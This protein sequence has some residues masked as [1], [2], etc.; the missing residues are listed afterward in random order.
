MPLH[1]R[2]PLYLSA[3]IFL[4]VNPVLAQ[5]LPM[6]PSP[7]VTLDKNLADTNIKGINYLPDFTDP[8]AG[9]VMGLLQSP[10]NL[11]ELYA[12]TVNGGV[13][14]SSNGGNSWTAMGDHLA[15]LSIGAITFD[16]TNPTKLWIGFGKLSSLGATGG[17]LAG[18]RVL[19]TT[20]NTW[21]MPAMAGLVK[22]DVSGLVVNGNTIVLGAKTETGAS[23]IWRSVDAGASFQNIT[24]GLSAGAITSLVKG[25]G[26]TLYAAILNDSSV[27]ATGVY[28][29]DDSGANW[30]QLSTLN[31]LQNRG[32]GQQMT[33]MIR[34]SVGKDGVLVASLANPTITQSPWHTTKT[35]YPNTPVSV[36]MS[37]DKGANWTSLGI[38]GTNEVVNGVPFFQNVYQSGQLMHGRVLA[39]PNDASIFYIS[40]DA[41][42]PGALISKNIKTSIGADGWSGRLFR[43]NYNAT[44]GETLWTAITDNYSTGTVTGVTGS[45]PHADSRFMMIDGMGNLLQ[46]DDGGI[47]KRTLPTRNDGAWQSLNGNL[48]VGEVHTARWNSTTHTAA[49]TNQDNGANIQYQKYQPLHVVVGGG[50]GGVVAINPNVGVEEGRVKSAIYS[51][52]QEFGNFNRLTVSDPDDILTR[53]FLY[54]YIVKADETKSYLVKNPD[55]I[56]SQPPNAKPPRRPKTPITYG[57]ALASNANADTIAMQ[58]IPAMSLNTVDNRR[59]ALGGYEVFVGVDPLTDPEDNLLRIQVRQVTDMKGEYPA[60]STYGF[61]ALQYGAVNNTSALV[62]GTGI[63]YN[64]EAAG[65]LVFSPNVE[66]TLATTIHTSSTGYQAAL[67]DKQL[68]TNRIYATNSIDIIR[69][70]PI[71]GGNSYAF[72]NLN[73]NLSENNFYARRAL[74]HIYKYGVS[75]LVAGGVHSTE[76][77]NFLYTLRDPANVV[78]PVWDTRLGSIPNAAIWSLEYSVTDDLLL[79]GVMGRG[80]FILPDVTTY[81]PEATQLVF[82]Q[83]DNASS[84]SDAQLVDGTNLLGTPFSRSMTK[85]GSGALSLVGR[86]ALYSGGTYLNNGITL[87]NADANLGAP[88]IGVWFDGGTLKYDAAF[89][90]NRPIVLQSNNGIIDTGNLAITQGNR[91]ISGVGGLAIV[92]GGSYTFNGANSYAGPTLVTAATVNAS[93]DSNFGAPNVDVW[94]DGGTLK[95]DAAFALNRPIVLQSNNGTIDNGNLAI[96]QG[97]RPI[98]GVGGLAIKGGGS[99]TFNGANSYAGPTLVTAATVNAS[100]DSNFGAPNIGVWLDG[101][102]LKYDAAFA[103]NRPIVLQSNNGMID[104]GNLAITQ[105]NRPISG[106]GALAIKGGGS[107]TFNGANSYAGPTLVTAATVNASLDSN[108]GAPLGAVIL[109]SATLNLTNGFVPNL[110][111]AWNRPLFIGSGNSLLNTNSNALAFTGGEI[112]TYGPAVGILSFAGTPMSMGANLKLNAIWNA[113]LA[114]PA[115]MVLRG[116]GGVT[117]DLNVAGTLYPGNSPGTFAV[118]GSVVQASGSNFALDIDGA[119]TGNGAGNYSRLV[120]GSDYTAGGNV[121]PVL[122]GMTG[123]ATNTFSPRIGQGFSIV[124]ATGSVLGSYDSVT[125]PSSGLLPGTR[126]DMVYASNAVTAYATPSA[127]SNIS[128]AGV[129]SNNNRQQLGGVLDQNRPVAGVRP[130][131]ATSKALYDSLYA[132]SVN[133]L[134]VSMDQLAGVAY[135]QLLQQNFE[136]TK[137]L[138]DQTMLEIGNQRRGEGRNQV[139]SADSAADKDKDASSGSQ[140]QAWSMAIG[141]VSK[142]QGDGVGYQMNNTLR[143]LLG[144]VQKQLTPQSLAGLSVAYADSYPTTIQ[145]M[146]SGPSQNLQVMAYASHSLD[147]G[148]FMQGS[149]GGGV[150]QIYANRSISMLNG[151]YSSTLRTLNAAASAMVGWASPVSHDQPRLELGLGLNYIS[152]R[153]LG[154]TDSGSQSAYTLNIASGNTNSLNAAFGFKVISPVKQIIGVNWRASALAGVSHEFLSDKANVNTTFM[155]Q[156]LQVQSGSIGRYR[157]NI[158]VSISGDVSQSTSISIGL[159]NQ[160][161]SNWNATAAVASIKVAF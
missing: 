31:V 133:T 25:P 13:W 108:F 55:V 10:F 91:P 142:L 49:T 63:G 150:G 75:A 76:D 21:S 46:T 155:N 103:L 56:S 127:Y 86:N 59:F 24:A 16:E 110:A 88:N 50:D 5:W 71:G 33:A 140:E 116:T 124:T 36:F 60:L 19:D 129:A 119:G 11:N 51:S 134:P 131:S 41:Q 35:D 114:V 4:Y 52:S 93:L 109:T 96:T 48:Q 57:M 17:A 137:F 45:G 118:V 130:G 14:K 138:I 23:S 120:V 72:A 73:G 67:F 125:Q 132:Q 1:R 15:S 95:Y 136:N 159:F 9:A 126:F 22:Q 113:D 87:V 117:G 111:G 161:A 154:L 146:G 81:F 106:V 74:D 42:G 8:G 148:Y 27:T 40:G 139:V 105:G 152:M 6:G 83:A 39:D 12:G 65:V 66:S 30:T 62:A 102:T 53:T 90:L 47:Y 2:F 61:R 7:V 79:A 115:G 64:P 100:L 69:G 156:S 141:R 84:P 101:G 145:N 157:A 68:G 92:G 85:T 3:L 147:S 122:R 82:G 77:G 149:A 32:I 34:L 29:S 112:D 54:P 80:I 107:Y 98:S 37:R 89:A 94:L 28:R 78:T 143:G 26:S 158:G 97:N 123:N 153:N 70:V 43:G 160:F 151:S 99:Y 44:T 58:F 38:P 135:P 18:V 128:A 20:T 121:V 104:T 144:G